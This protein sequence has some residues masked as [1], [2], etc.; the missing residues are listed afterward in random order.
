MMTQPEQME[1][2]ALTE[3]EIDEANGGLTI[4]LFGFQ[5]DV[6]LDGD[7]QLHVWVGTYKEDGSAHSVRLI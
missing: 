5:L 1:M 3:A 4:K 2:R 7:K 6:L